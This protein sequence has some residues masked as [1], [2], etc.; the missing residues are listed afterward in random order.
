MTDTMPSN[1][2]VVGMYFSEQC[3]PSTLGDNVDVNKP[4]AYRIA[5]P[6]DGLRT[7][8]PPPLSTGLF[9]C[10]VGPPSRDCGGKS[11]F[12]LGTPQ[13][14]AISHRSQSLDLTIYCPDRPLPDGWVMVGQTH[15]QFCNLPGANNAW[16]LRRITPPSLLL[17]AP[18]PDAGHRVDTAAAPGTDVDANV[19]PLWKCS[20]SSSLP[21]QGVIIGRFQ[22]L[23]CPAMSDS[24]FN[25]DQVSILPAIGTGQSIQ[26]CT[27]SPVPPGYKTLTGASPGTLART[28]ASGRRIYNPGPPVLI[29]VYKAECGGSGPNAKLIF[30]PTI[31]P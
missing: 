30:Y 23:S 31:G 19:N 24:S 2:I 22:S 8:L 5:E 7:C 1:M 6:A 18:R 27:N 13:R 26:V 17:P 14:C 15:S 29:T 11:D 21:P 4:N 9:A 10:D 20:V 12:G 3:P 25:A 28:T 16:V